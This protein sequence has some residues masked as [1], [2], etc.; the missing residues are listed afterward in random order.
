MESGLI[1]RHPTGAMLAPKSCGCYGDAM[2]LRLF[3]LLAAAV[4]CTAAAPAKPAPKAPAPKSA[5]SK[6]AGAGGFDL[7]DPQA[8][9][10]LLTAAGA[11]AKVDR[12]DDDSALVGV[13][14]VAANF[15]VQFAGCD[16]SGRDCK[17]M[18]F[19][20]PTEGTPTVAQLNAFDQTSAACR[21]YQ[22]RGGRAHVL[23]SA[24]L[25]A[26]D[27]REHAVAHLA[28]WQ[29]CIAEFHQFLTDPNAYLAE[30]P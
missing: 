29:G 17:V 28:A 22:D 7:R 25:F 19:D 27:S 5:A 11:T 12:H 4:A 26:D 6:P 14:S 16:R 30:A 23:Y 18:L 13:T 2:Q 21:G 8:L 10:S 9:A 20:Q 24:L 3:A 1:R 15:S